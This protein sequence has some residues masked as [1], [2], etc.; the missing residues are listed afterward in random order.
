MV[1][2]EIA[3]LLLHRIVDNRHPRGETAVDIL[4]LFP[5]MNR[6]ARVVPSSAGGRA[7]K[8]LSLLSPPSGGVHAESINRNPSPFSSHAMSIRRRFTLSPESISLSSVLVL[9]SFLPPFL[10]SFVPSSFNRVPFP[11]PVYDR[12]VWEVRRKPSVRNFTSC[13]N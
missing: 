1:R 11:R 6:W 2:C 9:P 4:H 12:A 5:G 7:S 8:T 10:P 13:S 3:M